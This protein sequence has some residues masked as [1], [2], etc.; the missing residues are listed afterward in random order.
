MNIVSNG[1]NEY[2][3]VTR[4]KSRTI[5]SEPSANVAYLA[6]DTLPPC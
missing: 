1:M 6:P 5:P 2:A 4:E 3:E